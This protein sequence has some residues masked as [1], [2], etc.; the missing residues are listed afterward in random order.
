MMFTFAACAAL[1]SLAVIPVKGIDH[2]IIVGGTGILQYN[3]NQVVCSIPSLFG[4]LLK[5]CFGVRMQQSEILLL[6]LSN[7]RTTRRLSRRFRT[8][9]NQL[10]M[11]LIPDCKLGR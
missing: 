5:Q 10:L 6:S 3:P 9:V 7:K 8:H 11:A 2:E 1:V 4:S